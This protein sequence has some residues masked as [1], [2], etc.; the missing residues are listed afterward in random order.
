METK[1]A[2]HRY[3]LAA[4]ER[5]DLKGDFEE[6]L[7][8]LHNISE[9]EIIEHF[10]AAAELKIAKGVV[11]SKSI[12]KTINTLI[13]KRLREKGWNGQSPIFGDKRFEEM[14]W[15]LDFAKASNGKG[16]FSV[17]VVF[18]NAGSL[19]WNLIKPVLACEQNHVK[20][21]IETKIGVVVLATKE[22]KAA[23]GFDN[24]IATFEEAPLYLS[25]MQNIISSTPIIIV[26]LCAPKTFKVEHY[27]PD[28]ETKKAGRIV[29]IQSGTLGEP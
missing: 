12:S 22:M 16:T 19:G 8:V 26:G 14:G 11:P 25:A 13:D 28:G 27:H 6:L 5:D 17:E 20:K 9:E 1:L 2:E 24:A 7:G 23:G 18:N 15:T 10:N 3:A 29:R 21:A 4:A